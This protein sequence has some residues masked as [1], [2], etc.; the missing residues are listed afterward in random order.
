MTRIALQIICIIIN[1]KNVTSLMQCRLIS[2]TLKDERGN[3]ADQLDITLDDS[4]AQLTFLGKKNH[5]S[6]M[7]RF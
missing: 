7:A 5:C 4:D 6:S 3:K 1:D 2:L